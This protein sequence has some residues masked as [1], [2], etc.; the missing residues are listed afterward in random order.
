MIYSVYRR[1]SKKAM[2]KSQQASKN[3]TSR[4]AASKEKSR[5]LLLGSVDIG[6][7]G[8]DDKGVQ[9]VAGLLG[10][11]LQLG[12]AA[13]GYTQL[14]LIDLARKV[15]LVALQMRFG[16]HKLFPLSFQQQ[17]DNGQVE[18]DQNEV[19]HDVQG[20]HHKAFSFVLTGQCKLCM[21]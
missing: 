1:M 10:D 19:E 12:L 5:G 7:Y 8:L 15:T 18:H 21:L 16:C 6:I 4:S 9:A 11:L 17:D 3:T 2:T 13:L 14:D 20:I